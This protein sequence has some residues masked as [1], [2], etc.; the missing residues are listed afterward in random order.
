MQQWERYGYVDYVPSPLP[1]PAKDSQDKMGFTIYR[2]IV[3]TAGNCP[4]ITE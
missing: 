3:R 1:R 4:S 2:E